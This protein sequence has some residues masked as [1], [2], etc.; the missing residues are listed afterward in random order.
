MEIGNEK[1]TVEVILDSED[2]VLRGA[3]LCIIMGGCDEKVS[4]QKFMESTRGQEGVEDFHSLQK[5]SD[6]LAELDGTML[7]NLK[8]TIELR[9]NGLVHSVVAPDQVEE[10]PLI[11]L[12]NEPVL[13]ITSNS[14]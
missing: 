4:E 8:G 6:L 12:D 14:C 13:I 7:E 11:V 10:E 5:D 1:I 2:D 9:S 3:N